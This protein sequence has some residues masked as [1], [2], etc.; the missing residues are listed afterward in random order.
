MTPPIVTLG[1]AGTDHE[2]AAHTYRG[3]RELDADVE[4]LPSFEGM[5]DYLTGNPAALA[6]ANSAH[7]DVDL[8]TTR[9]WRQFGIVDFFGLA[10]MPL[11]LV[12]RRGVPADGS[13]AIMSSTRGYLDLTRYSRVETVP[14]KPVAVHRVL[15]GAVEHAVVS[16]H[17]YES[18]PAE[19]ELL[20]VIGPVECCYLVYGRRNAVPGSVLAPAAPWQTGVPA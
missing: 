9:L 12:R 20:E 7:P 19:L 5:L 4:L 14:A 13:I 2:R 8:L 15:A 17:S 6:V 11:A 16:L 10:T 18:H 1:P 3:L